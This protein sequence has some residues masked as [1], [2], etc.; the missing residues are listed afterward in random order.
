[1]NNAITP[2]LHSINPYAPLISCCGCTAGDFKNRRCPIGISS[3]RRLPERFRLGRF[4][5][6]RA[7]SITAQSACPED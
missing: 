5:K 4:L 2:N 6:A 1:M 7:S 3:T